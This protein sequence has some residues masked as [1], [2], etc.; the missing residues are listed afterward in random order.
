VVY[1]GKCC[2]FSP[3]FAFLREARASKAIIVCLPKSA[4]S[5]YRR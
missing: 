5:I 4:I 3:A 2:G 1:R